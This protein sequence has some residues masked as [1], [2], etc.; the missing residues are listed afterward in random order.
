MLFS[1]NRERLRLCVYLIIN[2]ML[3]LATTKDLLLQQQHYWEWS[4]SFTI[5]I[6]FWQQIPSACVC[7]LKN[8]ISPEWGVWIKAAHQYS[9]VLYL[10]DW[11]CSTWWL[12]CLLVGDRVHYHQILKCL[13]QVA[14]RNYFDSVLETTITQTTIK[15]VP[16]GDLDFPFLPCNPSVH[17]A[18]G[19][20]WG[21]R[22]DCLLLYSL[23]FALT[24]QRR[25]RST[26]CFWNCWVFFSC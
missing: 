5:L 7:L 16:Q 26:H 3:F 14:T 20:G 8:G 19:W 9:L 2:N 11:N 24:M 10:Q 13:Q 23:F 25:L 4:H 17:S 12:Y 18:A 6:L 21:G 22:W 1:W 15:S